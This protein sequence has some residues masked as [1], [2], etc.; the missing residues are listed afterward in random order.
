[1]TL[2]FRNMTIEKEKKCFEKSKKLLKCREQFT[3]HTK[4]SE[5]MMLGGL[6][7]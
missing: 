7:L 6:G 5:V 3:K 2:L 4:F 1:M